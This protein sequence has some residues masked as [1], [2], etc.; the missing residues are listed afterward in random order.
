[1]TRLAAVLSHRDL[2]VAE[3]CAARLDGELFRLDGCFCPVDEIEQSRHRG[4]ALA[5]LLPDRLIAEQCTAAWLWGVIDQAP[6]QHQFCAS[7]GAR[8]RPPAM[9]RIAVREVVIDDVSTVMI[10]GMRVT[11]M[12]RTVIDLARF[13]PHFGAKEVTMLRGLMALGKLDI[14]ACRNDINSR[15]NLPGKKRAMARITEAVAAGSGTLP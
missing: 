10:G 14:E 3:L 13:S 2:P 4:A 8:V 1:M 12:L 11:T 15:R 6:A 7:L 5:A 9:M